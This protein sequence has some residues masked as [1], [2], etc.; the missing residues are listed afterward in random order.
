[1]KEKLVAQIHS[2]FNL[3]RNIHDVHIGPV[4]LDEQIKALERFVR[5]HER[6]V[7]VGSALLEQ[8]RRIAVVAT[9]QDYKAK[10]APSRAHEVLATGDRPFEASPMLVCS[11][12]LPDHNG[13]C[14]NCDEPAEG[15]TQAAFDAVLR[16]AGQGE[17]Q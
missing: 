10:A 16:C 13:E 5:W 11:E 15:H 6:Q 7:Q 2:H 14:L 4:T 1:M 12:Y 9:A 17:A 3:F 8:L